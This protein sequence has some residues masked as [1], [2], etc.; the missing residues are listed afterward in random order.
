[1]VLLASTG[2]SGAELSVMQ[3]KTLRQFPVKDE[4]ALKKHQKAI[5]IVTSDKSDQRLR[6]N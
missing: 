3:S 6:K 5:A 1:M 2:I 4:V